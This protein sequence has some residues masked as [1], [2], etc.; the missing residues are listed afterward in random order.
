MVKVYVFFGG[1]NQVYAKYMHFTSDYAP[2]QLELILKF[3]VPRLLVTGL[4]K[5]A[6]WVEILAMVSNNSEGARRISK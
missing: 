2:H 1:E 5:P 4:A 6:F 3:Y